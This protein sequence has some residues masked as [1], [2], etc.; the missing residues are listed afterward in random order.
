MLFNSREFLLGFFPIVCLLFFAAGRR[1]YRRAALG[2]LTIGSVL[3]Y[4]WWEPRFL[5]VLAISIYFN[6]QCGKEI[7]RR[8]ETHPKSS[9]RLLRLGIVINL[10]AL[11]FFKYIGFLVEVTNQLLGTSVPAMQPLLPLGISFFT[12]TQIAYLVDASRGEAREYDPLDYTLF[13]T[14]FPHLIA[15]PILHH[16]EMMPQFSQ[17]QTFRFDGERVA[18]GLELFLI[19]LAKKVVLA[20]SFAPYAISIFAAADAGASISLIEAWAGALAYTFQLYFDFSGYSDMAVGSALVLGIS[21]PLN[22]NSPYRSK[23]ISEFWRRWHMS[24]SRF[25]REY[26]YFPLGGNRD[27]EAL[28]YRNL[29][30][31]MIIGGVWHGAGWTFVAWGAYHGGLLAGFHFWNEKLGP[32]LWCVPIQLVLNRWTATLVTFVAVTIGWVIFRA[33]T[34]G[35]A[36]ALLSAMFGGGGVVIPPHLAGVAPWFSCSSCSVAPLMLIGNGA[37]MSLVELLGL[38][39]VGAAIVFLSPPSQSLR[40]PVRFAAILASAGFVIQAVFFGRGASEF[41]YFQF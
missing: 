28:R 34:I 27:G 35:G 32:R 14:F 1:G 11:G 37:I 24:L 39:A 30:L 40:Q 38:L 31:T 13:V 19:G 22:F 6:F 29:L 5:L 12:F 10:C 9:G 15:G 25:L 2:I 8:A 36:E 23:N 18:S 4:A 17:A 20:D 41:L 16:K 21:L 7:A 26:V 3:F 33:Q